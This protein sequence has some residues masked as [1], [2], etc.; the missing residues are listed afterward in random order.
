MCFNT[1]RARTRDYT[2]CERETF[3]EYKIVKMRKLSLSF[4]RQHSNQ[5][6]SLF[7]IECHYKLETGYQ[8]S[9]S[10]ENC[11]STCE[12]YGPIKPHK[13]VTFTHCA[14]FL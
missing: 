3:V 1:R 14:F 9:R 8:L 12:K 6:T 7:K 10:L 5:N 13:T 11:T 2:V 4:T